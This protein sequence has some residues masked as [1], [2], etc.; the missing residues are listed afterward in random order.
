MP[1]GVVQWFDEAAGEAAVVRAGR[2]YRAEARELEPVARHPGA[3][4]HFDIHRTR[5]VDQA[6]RVRLRPGTRVSH[7]QRRFGDLTGAHRPDTKG[8]AP[9]AR[10]HPELGRALAAHPLEVVRA[11]AR[12]VRASRLDEVLALYAPEATLH[13]DGQPVRGRAHLQSWF[14]TGPLLGVEVEPS[15]R[16]EAGLVLMRYVGAGGG[17]DGIEVRSRIAHGLIAEQWIEASRPEGAAITLTTA[18]GPV[19][20]TIV[21]HGEVPTD[22]RSYADQQLGAVIENIEEPVLFARVKL[23]QAPDPACERPAIA[24][25]SVDINGDLVRAQLAGHGMRE[26]IDLLVSRLRTKLEHRSQ[27]RQALRKRPATSPPGEWRHGDPRTQRPDHFDRPADER[28]LVRHKTYAPDELTPDEAAFDMDQLDVDFYL[29]RDL[30]SGED[31]LLERATAGSYRLTRLH[32]SPVGAGPTAVVLELAERPVP[33]LGLDEAIE[34]IT[35]EGG[36]YLFFADA[37]TG[38]G[39]V[40]YHRYDGHYGLIVP[41]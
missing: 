35:V 37:A 36:P 4:V 11:W 19:T 21:T 12:A 25:V 23:T 33:S 5:G 6:V 31:A 39:N 26:A 28:E 10:S 7:H 22:A 16:G 40:L 13:I 34:R 8:S 1:D 24:Q 32:P 2:V 17:P 41:E 15:I 30:A 29:F 18:T 3:R 38:R 27:H 14:E 20:M 9:F